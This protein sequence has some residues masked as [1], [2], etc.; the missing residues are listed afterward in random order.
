MTRSQRWHGLQIR[1]TT[2][3][4]RAKLEALEDRAL[5]STYYAATASDLIADI[6]AANLQ[7]GANTIAL[8][9]PTTSPYVLT[10]VDNTTDGATGTPVIAK[11]DTLTIVGNGD[12]IE[13]STATGT[14]AFR[15]FDVAYGNSL[16]L[17]NVT[18][19]GGLAQGSGAAADGGA[20]YNTGTLTVS[21]CN[22]VGDSAATGGGIYN[23]SAVGSSS[24]VIN[25]TVSG[26]TI[27]NNTAYG[28]TVGQFGGG[29]FNNYKGI[30]SVT[31]ST[32]SGNRS[33]FYGGG[34]DNW[35]ALSVSGCTL[36]GNSA[37]AGA[38]I[39]NRAPAAR[40]TATLT[41]CTF[42]NNYAGGGIF[43]PSGSTATLT[44]C[45]FSNNS[46]TSG[47]AL[48]VGGS[49]TLTNCTFSN[50][51]AH[52][53]GG[54]VFVYDVPLQNG[55]VLHGSAT[56]TNCTLSL[57]SASTGGGICVNPAYG[58]GILNLTNTI[59]AGNIASTGPDISGAV[60]TAD[61]NL[62]GNAT[63]ASGIV[64]GVNGNIVGGNGNPVINADLG[65]LQNNGGP[66]Q[67]MALLAGS[68]AIGHADNALAPATDQRGVKRRDL[69]G[70][71]T[72][73]GAFEV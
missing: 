27:T 28:S 8:T 49:A 33:R 65:P 50:N 44:N 66:T 18:L 59:V 53:N 22:I 21:Q 16:T 5:P 37:V 51:S 35:G 17:E 32:L 39:A 70:E 72:D 25:L 19:Q 14:P 62:V 34:I 55:V 71:L 43:I 23:T 45:T 4:F 36:S 13:R 6:K 52:S 3:R 64:N 61:H 57:N 56:L 31:G 12:T 20:I 63:G 73:I 67:T 38:G 42:S 1:P 69:A 7:G 15:L 47:G 46:A 2:H 11:Q 58:G 54:A 29:I 40:G 48:S 60:A 41:N 24:H 9:A 68:P 10:A 30:L 26:C